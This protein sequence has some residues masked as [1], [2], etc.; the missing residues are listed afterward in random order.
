MTKIWDKGQAPL[1]E[2]VEEL[3]VGDDYL[4]DRE[5][6]PHDVRGSVAHARGLNRIGIV[7]DHELKLLVEALKNLDASFAAGEWTVE[8]GDE[9]VHSAVE[10]RLIAELGDA[11][12]KLHTGRSR[13]DQVLLDMRLF[14]RDLTLDSMERLLCLAEALI[15]FGRD[16]ADWLMPGY[17][18][19]RPAMPSSVALWA[20]AHAEALIED[21]RL[22][23]KNHELL[24]SCP[25][26]LSPPG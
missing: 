23:L 26:A 12:R 9:D 1:P 18:H 14:L 24:D 8:R 2:W 7:D 21:A 16:K 15:E 5:L 10:R 3:T 17:T 11:G 22:F 19:L 20:G 4:F 25:L 6:V 13:N